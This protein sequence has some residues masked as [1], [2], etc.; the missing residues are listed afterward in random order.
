MFNNKGFTLIELL[1]VIAIIGILTTA[2][3]ISMNP[4]EKIDAAGDARRLATLAEI[5]KAL[6]LYM[7]ENSKYPPLS[8]VNTYREG[9]NVEEFQNAIKPYIKI[10]LNDTFLGPYYG[11]DDTEFYYYSAPTDNYQHYGMAVLL[12]SE[13]FKNKGETDGGYYSNI[14]EIGHDPV[15]CKGKYSGGDSN[16]I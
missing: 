7:L 2:L 12:L 6:E 1:V 5:Q 15:Y 3:F 14:Y 13:K 16:W 11:A 9:K 8:A 10:D 4:N